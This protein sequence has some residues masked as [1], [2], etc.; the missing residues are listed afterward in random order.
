MPDADRF[1]VAD[2]PPLPPRR[3]LLV[4]ALGRR[5]ARILCRA[6][7]RGPALLRRERPRRNGH[8]A[9]RR[10]LRLCRDG[11]HHA[12]RPRGRARAGRRA[13]AGVGEI[14]PD[15]FAHAAASGGARRI[16]FAGVRR[17]AAVAPR[18]VRPADARIALGAGRSAHRGLG[19]LD[20]RPERD[21]PARH[22]RG[23][24][25][26][27]ALSLP[28]ARN[29]R[30]RA[31][32][33]RHAEPDAARA[34]R[35]LPAGRRRNPRAL[36]VRRRHAP[37]RRRGARAA[38]RAEL[39]E[40]DDGRAP[41]AGPDDPADPRVDRPSARA[42]PHPRRRTQL[43]RHE[44]RH[45]G[46]VR[47][48]SVRLR[49]PQRHVR[50]DPRRGARELRL[51]RRRRARATRA[52]HPR[53]HPRAAPRRR[54]VAASRGTSRHGE[55]AR[56]QLEPSADRPDGESQH[57]AGRRVA[58]RDDRRHRARRDDGNEL[59]VVDRRLAQQVP[60]RLRAGAAD[61][62]R[63]SSA[64][65]SRI[66]TT[67]ASAR[68][69]GAASRAS[70]MRTPCACWARRIA[71]R[72]NPRRSS[73]SAMRRPR[74]CS[75]TWPSSAGNNNG[76]AWRNSGRGARWNRTSPTS[77]ICSTASRRPAKPTWP[78][79]PA[80]RRISSASIAARSA[81]PATSSSAT[82]TSSSFTARGTRPTAC[83]WSATS[84]PTASGCT[85]PSWGCAR[86]C[87]S[88]MPTRICSSPPTWCRRGRR[89]ASRCLRRRT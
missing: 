4:A 58:G 21:A 24:R 8:G 73:A 25:R 82:S 83:R 57:R 20:R 70:A 43:R 59:L 18:L 76:S 72:A 85:A 89:A 80:R 77:P 27:A 69:S 11:R 3:R 19:R 14:C 37:H 12:G 68:I 38:R 53:R 32:G 84:R 63:A 13:R 46:D 52:P 66:P 29:V 87:P 74:A 79:F 60:V 47:D 61:R 54:D 78:A 44:L 62:A 34:S 35:H 75:R 7:E 51:G 23:R 71:A 39:P 81:S 88:S 64:R 67:A 30:D 9:C 40:R 28:A 48:L 36:R 55:R 26:R 6:Q 50:S 41:H 33:R 22:Q 5:G 49:P 16:R 56:R 10:R 45:A 1:T 42:R 2:L 17:P 65:S 31:R 86:R 15:R